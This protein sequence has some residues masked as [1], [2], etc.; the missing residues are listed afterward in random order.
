MHALALDAMIDMVGR[1]TKNHA[2]VLDV[3]S[4]DYNGSY[5]K[6]IVDRGW[7]YV[8]IDLDPGPNVDIVAR[9]PY[10]YD[11]A[12]DYFDIVVSGST[13]EHVANP[14]S[15]IA[16]VSRVLKP[17]G[18]LCIIT[19]W[20]HPLHRYPFDYWRIMPD[21]MEHLF[22]STNCLCDYDIKIVNSHDIAGSAF[23][24]E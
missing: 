6:M 11:L 2:N 24:C 20:S 4:R 17:G 21:G 14:F 5:R 9:G 1:W 13:L 16:E 3:G 7:T 18:L 22:D 12:E 8:G 23:K 15:W 19:H 10:S